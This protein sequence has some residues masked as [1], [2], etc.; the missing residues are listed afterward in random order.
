MKTID[1]LLEQNRAWAA[2]RTAADPRFFD[3]LTHIQRPDYLW[4]GCA[5]SR[6]PA[7]EIVGLEPGELFVHRNVANI[8][9]PGD[10]NCMGVVEYAIDV[11]HVRRV[12]VCGHYGCGGVRAVLD[13]TFGGS[14]HVERWLNP[15]RDIAST[16][17]AELSSLASDDARWARLCELNVIEQ[18]SRLESSDVLAGAR[19]RRITVTVHP[20][21]YSLQDGLL[22][23]LATPHPVQREGREWESGP[24]EAV[25]SQS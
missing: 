4:I 5:D 22:H 1:E 3:K 19:L 12:I 21:I 8:V 13:N 2:R 16:H 7:N 24:A 14:A 17:A 10:P 15:L 18:A 20:L 11:L 6:V 23:E 9:A 25:K